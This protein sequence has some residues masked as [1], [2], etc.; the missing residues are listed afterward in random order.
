MHA[1]ASKEA[2]YAGGSYFLM[3]GRFRHWRYGAGAARNHIDALEGDA[4]SDAV[5]CAVMGGGRLRGGK[6]VPLHKT[7]TTVPSSCL[8]GRPGVEDGDG[9]QGWR[10]LV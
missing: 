2:W 6:V 1:D 8:A 4:V 7:L 3:C 10:R 9:L 5:A